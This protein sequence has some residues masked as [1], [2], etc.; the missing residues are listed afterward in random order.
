MAQFFDAAVR[1][2][3]GIEGGYVDHAHDSGGKTK[4]GITEAVARAN[5]YHGAMQD[6]DLENAIEIYWTQYWRVLGL[7]HVAVFS[8]KIAA[9][10]FDTAVNSGTGRAAQFLQRTLNVLNRQGQLFSDI[11]VDGALGPMTRAALRQFLEHRGREGE[12]VVIVALNVLQGEFLIR[13]AERREKD[14][15]F[16]YGQLLH[17]VVDQLKED[18]T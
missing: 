16:I 8:P 1:K 13:L 12:Q 15:S 11:P 3:L 2:L 4:Y 10:L 17:R 5:G 7:D 14:E 9:E 6:L 18:L